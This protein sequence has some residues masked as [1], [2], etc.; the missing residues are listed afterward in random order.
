MSL[1]FSQKSRARLLNDDGEKDISVFHKLLTGEIYE[2]N[3]YLV[4]THECKV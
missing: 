4:C 2:N 3:M 1:F